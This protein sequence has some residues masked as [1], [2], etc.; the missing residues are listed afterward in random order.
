MSDLSKVLTAQGVHNEVVAREDLGEILCGVVDDDVGTEVADQLFL[1]AV[2][3]RGHV[4]PE[5]LGELNDGGPQPSGSGVDEDSLPRLNVRPLDQH[6]PRRQRDQRDGCGLLQRQ[7]GRLER[8]VVFVDGDVLGEG[9]DTKIAGPCEHFVTDGEAADVGADLGDHTGHVVAEHERWLVLEEL[10]EL[11]VADHA[12]QR[13]DAR[14][15]HLD[16]NVPVTDLGSG[17][18]AARTSSLPYRATTN[19]FMW[20]FPSS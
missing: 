5:V 2:G 3:G 20:S 6:L 15:A 18:S 12:V 1:G 13:V 19:A 7:G 16:E 9:P 8:D 11:S 14:C 10:F 17:T 4:G